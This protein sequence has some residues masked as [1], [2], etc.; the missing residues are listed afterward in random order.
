[1]YLTMQTCYNATHTTIYYVIYREVGSSRVLTDL[2]KTQTHSELNAFFQN[3]LTKLEFHRKGK[4]LAQFLY[5]FTENS[6]HL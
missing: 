5:L 6:W 2:G 4:I 3:V 1:M